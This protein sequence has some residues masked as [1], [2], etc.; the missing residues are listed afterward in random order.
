[1]VF[2][3]STQIFEDSLL[4]VTFHVIPVLNHTMSNRIVDTVSRCLRVGEGLISNEE[5]EIFNSTF[6]CKIAWF[7]RNSGGSG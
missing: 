6:R 4:P 1:V 5:V 3:L 7:G 2:G